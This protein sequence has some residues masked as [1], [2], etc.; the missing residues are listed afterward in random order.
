MNDPLFPARGA[1]PPSLPLR[2][3]LLVAGVALVAAMLFWWPLVAGGALS[4]RDWS[5][6]HYHYFD[7]VRS[8]LARYG[9]LPLYMPDA[10]MTQNFLA[11]AES[12]LLS[13]FDPLL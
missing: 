9:T 1:A 13:P 11:N 8:S 10:V 4:G 5:S 6:H 3:G 7:W 12:P 2:T